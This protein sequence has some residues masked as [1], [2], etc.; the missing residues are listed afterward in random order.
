MTSKLSEIVIW[1]LQNEFNLDISTMFRIDRLLFSNIHIIKLCALY[2][3][4]I[5]A[6][7]RHKR[8][9]IMFAIC[10]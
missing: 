9:Y 8:N 4:Q 7:F 5:Q 1:V 6:N 3:K 2:E 10:L